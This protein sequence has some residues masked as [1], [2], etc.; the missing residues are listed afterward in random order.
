[1]KIRP[2]DYR[3]Q[4]YNSVTAML[5][6][7]DY[8]VQTYNQCHNHVTE[9]W[10]QSTDVQP[11]SQPCY[12]ARTTEYRRT[13]SVTTMLQSHDYR[14][15]TYNQ[16]HNHVTEFLQPVSQPCYRARTTEQKLQWDSLQQH[17]AHSH[18]LMLY[19]IRN[20]LVAIPAWI[21]LQPTLVHTRG[22]ETSYRQIQCNTSMYS[23]T[24]FP[25]A[26]KPCQLMSASGRRTALGMHGMPAWT[27]D[28]KVVCLFVC[29]S[30][31]CIVTK[32][33]KDLSKFLYH[34]KDHL[35]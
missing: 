19:R 14:V 33:K 25:C 18:V 15:Q 3:V 12:R 32:R 1:L 2:Q 10:L 11:G 27:S 9:P 17:R 34:T 24:F 31:T 28:E 4:T 7:Q 5:Q 21:Y 6:S 30:H 29:L 13:T 26:I 20:G 16:C 35:A 8:R 22:F 23:Q